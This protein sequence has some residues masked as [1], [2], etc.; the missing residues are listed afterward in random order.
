VCCLRRLRHNGRIAR[1]TFT[2][3]DTIDPVLLCCYRGKR[4]GRSRRRRHSAQ[5]GVELNFGFLNICSLANKLD[6]LLDVCREQLIDV[7]F[8][9][10]TW[11]DADS[12]CFSRLLDRL[13]TFSLPVYVVGDFNIHLE[14]RHNGLID[15]H[16][17]QLIDDLSAHG[18]SNR[19]Q[20]ATRGPTGIIDIV[21]TRDDLPAPH[22]DVRDVGLSDHHL[23]HWSAPLRRGSPSTSL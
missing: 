19:V 18:L 9:A 22:V 5:A 3:L 15:P 14:R 4:S 11:H 12:V 6:D 21:A 20:S 17:T 10:E 16:A 8:L 2:A 23:L 1:I 13:A 7:V